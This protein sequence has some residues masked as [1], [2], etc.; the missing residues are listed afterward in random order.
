MK[1][2]K[3]ENWYSQY[4]FICLTY[5]ILLHFSFFDFLYTIPFNTCN[6][7]PLFDTRK[8]G[9]LLWWLPFNVFPLNLQI[10]TF[11]PIAVGRWLYLRLSKSNNR[12]QINIVYRHLLTFRHI[13]PFEVFPFDIRTKLPSSLVLFVS[14]R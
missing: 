8:Y 1:T 3:K 10:D 14:D 7:L 11:V 12:V 6:G 9:L 13:Y 5:S 4:M 2:S